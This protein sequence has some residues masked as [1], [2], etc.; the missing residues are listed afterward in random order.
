MPTTT[1]QITCAADDCDAYSLTAFLQPITPAERAVRH[2]RQLAADG[3]SD[4]EGR[5]YCP[6][7]PVT[8]PA[9]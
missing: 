1:H 3:W 9:P 4:V 6:D 5:D 7:H 2:R 8:V